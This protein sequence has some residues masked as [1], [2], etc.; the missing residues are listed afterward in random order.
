MGLPETYHE[1]LIGDRGLTPLKAEVKSASVQNEIRSLLLPWLQRGHSLHAG[2]DCSNHEGILGRPFHS[3]YS[4]QLVGGS[5][6]SKD[7]TH[8]G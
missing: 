6:T 8:R 3:L 5:K 7:Q 4:R 2:P 1:G